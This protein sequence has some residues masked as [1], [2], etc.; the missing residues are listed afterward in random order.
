[1][2]VVLKIGLCDKESNEMLILMLQLQTKTKKNGFHNFCALR[3]RG[4]KL[5]SKIP[6]FVFGWG[7]FPPWTPQLG[8]APAPHRGLGS[9]WT[10]AI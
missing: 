4:S 5:V 7:A 9:P 1:M 3:L 6:K 10:L 2:L 8:V